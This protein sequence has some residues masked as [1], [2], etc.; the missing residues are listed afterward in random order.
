[1]SYAKVMDID[2]RVRDFPVTAPLRIQCGDPETPPPTTA[3]VMQ[4]LMGAM[5]KEMSE[6][7]RFCAM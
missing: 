4:R 6:S 2:R 1:M 5:Y 3:L 7:T